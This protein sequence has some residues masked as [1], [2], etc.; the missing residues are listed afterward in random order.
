MRPLDLAEWFELGP[1]T[2]QLLARKRELCE[3]HRSTVFVT[4]D[5]VDDEARE[6]AEAI[7]EHVGRFHPGRGEPRLDPDLHPLDA[8]ARLVPEDLV[9]MVERDGRLVVGAGSV[10]FPN[11]WDL[12]SKLG[13][14]LA[15]VHAPVARLNDQ[16][17]PAIDAFLARLRPDRAYWRLGWGIID[18]DDPYTPLDGT[19]G[20][21]PVAPRPEQLYVRVERETLRRF[22]ATRCVL[23][24]IR[25]YLAPLRAV[26]AEPSA[27]QR[28]AA[29]V[30]T[31][32]DDVRGYKDLQELGD[33][34]VF[35]LRS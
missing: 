29:A 19:G 15:E 28:L 10:C 6:V 33:D 23:F 17:G 25:T 24:T 5:D 3:A 16:L 35:W 18:T 8:A 2:D 7:A 31:M 21:R 30:G 26:A 20:A 13:R 32:P 1:D 14:T 34:V 27:A 12:R 22:P 9:M 4:L 11:R